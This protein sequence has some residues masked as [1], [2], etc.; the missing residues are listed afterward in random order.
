MTPTDT[1]PAEA[2]KCS[3]DPASPDGDRSALTIVQNGHILTT[4]YGYQADA[5]YAL[6]N[7]HPAPQPDAAAVLK[8]VLRRLTYVAD[9]SYRFGD[10]LDYPLLRQSLENPRQVV[11]GVLHLIQQM[12]AA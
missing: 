12:G 5:V 8:E 10:D 11:A 9:P 6:M 7:T 4:L 2:P 1:T 3:Y